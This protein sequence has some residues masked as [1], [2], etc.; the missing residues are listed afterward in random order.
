M[1]NTLLQIKSTTSFPTNWKELQWK[2]IRKYVNRLQQRIYR[3][4]SLGNKRKTRQL[5]RLLMRSK[6]VLL[7]S[8]RRITQENKGRKT[9]GVDGITIQ[10]DIERMNLYR[11]MCNRTIAY[12]NPK[13]SY[14][15]YIK[16]KNGKLRPLSIPV[17]ID[18]I[19]QNVMKMALEPQWEYRFEPTS[20]G[21][22]PERGCHDAI[23]RIYK[24]LVFGKRRWVFEGDFKGC[25]DN[26][27][28]SHI[29]EQIKGIPNRKVIEKWLRAGYVDDGLFYSTKS[30]SGQG[31]VIS[32]LLANVA[33]HGME[34]ALGIKYY[35]NKRS[36]GYTWAV[37]PTAYAMTRYAD[38]FVVMCNTKQQAE[39][40]Y[41]KLKPY[42]AQRGLELEETK[43]KIVEVTKGFDFLGF[44]I[45]RY[46]TAKGEQLFIKPSKDSIK[47][48][49]RKISDI[50]YQVRGHKVDVLIQK[51]NPVILGIANYWRPEVSTKAFA[52]MDKHIV[53]VTYRFLRRTHR[54]K[55]NKWIR[56]RYFREDYRGISANRWILSSPN[57][58]NLQLMKMTWVHS[59]RNVLI[60]HDAS[61]FNAELAK[62]FKDR[63][64]KSRNQENGK[65]YA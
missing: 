18:R 21:F 36:D 34:K 10:T 5:Q 48:S 52:D 38:D 65:K 31:S 47:K 55:N 16:K 20:Y 59:K 17:I 45:R 19:W 23:E 40:V 41:N 26:L 56:E 51:L 28:H 60:K 42:L 30:G 62:Y 12:H 43:T 46:K 25:F 24:Y 50:T 1:R 4:E 22:R 11:K 61:P 35:V 33:L 13:P 58:H 27:N 32:P 14:R 15:T 63:K 7:L 49:K 9:A 37:N 44:N 53:N 54:K 2:Q 64:R 6:A 39:S 29:L 8:I 3:A 57:Q